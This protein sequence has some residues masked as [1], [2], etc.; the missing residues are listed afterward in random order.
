MQFMHWFER[1]E[2]RRHW[3]AVSDVINTECDAIAVCNAIEATGR[4]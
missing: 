3:V 4:G 1:A 2:Y